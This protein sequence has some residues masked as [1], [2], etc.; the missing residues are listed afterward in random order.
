MWRVGLWICWTW[1]GGRG[2]V[3][4]VVDWVAY[5][6]GETYV[7]RWGCCTGR[8]CCGGGLGGV[9]AVVTYGGG[10]RRGCWMEWTEMCWC[11]VLVLVDFALW[12]FS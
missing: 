2:V 5:L 4:G 12:M 11:L 10:G 7:W 8:V 6:H 9:C 3:E 1:T